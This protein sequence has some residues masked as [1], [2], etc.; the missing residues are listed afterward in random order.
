MVCGS[1]MRRYHSAIASLHKKHV[2]EYVRVRVLQATVDDAFHDP[3]F[4]KIVE[5]GK[6]AEKQCVEPKGGT[7]T[8]V[9]KVKAT[10]TYIK[11][12][13]V[14][15]ETDGPE[16]EPSKN[17]TKNDIKP[18]NKYKRNVGRSGE[19]GDW[20]HIGILSTT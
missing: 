17:K 15:C 5:K 14:E 13:V 18:D 8:D 20:G 9:P 1:E 2:D 19:F 10:M 4:S 7:A 11:A 3:N 6:A 12:V 16:E